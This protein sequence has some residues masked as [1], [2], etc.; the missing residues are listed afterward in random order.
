MPLPIGIA[1]LRGQIAAR[2]EATKASAQWAYRYVL[3]RDWT[4]Y[5]PEQQAAIVE[6]WY[7]MGQSTTDP[8]YTYIDQHIRKGDC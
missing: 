4:S 5:N 7:L 6:H 3:G 8:R 1:E 2:A